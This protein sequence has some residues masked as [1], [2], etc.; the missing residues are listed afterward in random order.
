L[1]NDADV[2]F[3]YVTVANQKDVCINCL[4]KPTEVIKWLLALYLGWA[5][6]NLVRSAIVYYEMK[7]REKTTPKNP[8]KIHY[9]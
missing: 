3:L 2:I 8:N 5:L 1:Q 9:W 4:S 7:K 6:N